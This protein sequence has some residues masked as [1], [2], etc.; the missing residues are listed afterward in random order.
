[1]S[2]L[3]KATSWTYAR[4]PKTRI[5]TKYAIECGEWTITKFIVGGIAR[6]MLW[7]GKIPTIPL[8]NDAESARNAAHTKSKEVA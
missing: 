4:D 2:D 6:Y 1:M 5:E 8:H 3:R 7:R